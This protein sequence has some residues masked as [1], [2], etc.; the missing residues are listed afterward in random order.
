MEAPEAQEAP[1]AEAAVMPGLAMVGG[2]VAAAEVQIEVE[3]SAVL[4]TEGAAVMAESLR[5]F[6]SF[7]ARSLSS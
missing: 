5:S 2:A 1:F 4:A 7:S 6:A 3:P